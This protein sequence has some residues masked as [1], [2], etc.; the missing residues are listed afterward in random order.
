MG[1]DED[2]CAGQPRRPGPNRHNDPATRDQPRQQPGRG[3]P[4]NHHLQQARRAA[5]RHGVRV[6]QGRPGGPELDLLLVLTGDG[7]PPTHLHG[8]HR[9]GDANLVGV[10][11]LKSATRQRRPVDVATDMAMGRPAR[12]DHRVQEWECWGPRGPHRTALLTRNHHTDPG[13]ALD[14]LM[15]QPGPRTVVAQSQPQRSQ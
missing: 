11:V 9:D 13:R 2:G 3:R 15:R 1:A 5:S 14:D 8:P 4:V 7:P 6:E 12:L 10:L